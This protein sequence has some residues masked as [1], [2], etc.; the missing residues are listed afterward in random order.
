MDQVPIPFCSTNKR[1]LNP[2]GRPCRVETDTGKDKRQAT[3]QLTIRAKGKQIVKPELFFFGQGIQIQPEET[4][5]YDA[6]DTIKIRWQKN[7]WADE[8]ICVEYF[9]DFREQTMPLGEVLLGMDNLRAQT[10]AT[11]RSILQ[12]LDV[13][14]ALTPADCTDAVSP[15]DHHVG[16][17]FEVRLAWKWQSYIDGVTEGGESDSEAEIDTLNHLTDPKRRMLIATWI[18]ELWTEFTSGKW[19]NLI[20]KSFVE[21]GF[22]VA[23][24][25]SENHLI[26]LDGWQLGEGTYTF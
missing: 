2:I 23:K 7:A 5:F 25:G 20:F 18:S 21:T 3:L 4:A 16:R 15:V 9:D 1:T 12:L 10:T 24:D 13:V 14:Y 17:W 26:K 11:C 22:C 6:L 19:D 8:R